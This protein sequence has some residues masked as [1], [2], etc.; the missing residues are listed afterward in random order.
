M[1]DQ[2]YLLELFEYR[3][4]ELYWKVSPY[5]RIAIGSRAGTTRGKYTT[6]GINGRRYY[7]HKIIFIMIHGY[8]LK[9]ITFIDGN[10]RNCK[11]ENLKEVTKSQLIAKSSLRI[12]NT[13]GYKGVSWMPSKR[14]WQVNL[15]KD[16]KQMCLGRFDNIETAHK[17]YC[18]AANRYHGEFANAG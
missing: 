10:V 18:E 16:G 13:S 14:K 9:T 7:A 5:R 4:G 3:D 15:T 6:V 17:A 11:I 2:K 1:L 12:D 8:C